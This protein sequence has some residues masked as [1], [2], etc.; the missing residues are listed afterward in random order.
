MS[1]PLRIGYLPLLDAGLLLVAAAKG[2][3]A[4]E[5]LKFELRREASWANLRDKLSLGIY[6]AAHMLAPAVVASALGL[7]GFVAPMIGACALGLDGNAVSVSPQLAGHLPLGAAA[8][9]SALRE[10]SLR[11][12]ASGLPP[13]RFAHVFP[14]SAHHYLLLLWL[15]MAHIEKREV[16]LTVTPPPLM[17]ESVTGYYIDGFCVGEPWNSLAQEAGA[18]K[19]LFPCVELIRNCPEKVLAFRRE[20]AEQAPEVVEAAAR[21]VRRAALWGQA[22]E[23]HAEFCALIAGGLEGGA[24]PHHVAHAIAPPTGE[25]W[26]RLD[27]AATALAPEQA[28]FLLALMAFAGQTAPT[29][30][31]AAHAGA[32]FRAF[33]GAPAQPQSFGLPRDPADWRAVFAALTE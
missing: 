7:G 27:A 26:L 4:E 22:A 18:A 19:V 6:D 16:R 24:L 5:G 3:D 13:L 23:N 20:T 15:R 14:Y 17:R 2:F 32:A 21:A 8:S 29:E 30:V 12:R 25:A 33:G 10:L 9:A 1:R 11:S 28:L 31:N